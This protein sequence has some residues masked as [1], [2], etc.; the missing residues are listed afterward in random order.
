MLAFDILALFY[1]S[2]TRCRVGECREHLPK[3]LMQLAFGRK[4][5]PK[6]GLGK[7]EPMWSPHN[8][9]K[10]VVDSGSFVSLIFEGNSM[11]KSQWRFSPTKGIQLYIAKVHPLGSG[12]IDA[13]SEPSGGTS[14]WCALGSISVGRTNWK[15]HHGC[16]DS[17]YFLRRRWYCKKK[18]LRI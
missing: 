17:G 9:V 11:P 10:L 15:M 7:L 3:T 8:L 12:Q 18:F 16:I 1:C 4:E 14:E 13:A 6:K 2:R 5:H